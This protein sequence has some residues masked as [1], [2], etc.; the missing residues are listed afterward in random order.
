MH[1]W[2]MEDAAFVQDGGRRDYSC[3]SDSGWLGHK[4]MWRSFRKERAEVDV[5]AK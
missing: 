3:M 5:V 2:M 4:S 1:F